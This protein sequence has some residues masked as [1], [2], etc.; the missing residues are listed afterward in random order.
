M[1][2]VDMW[3]YQGLYHGPEFIQIAPF[4]VLYTQFFFRKQGGGSNG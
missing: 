1:I 4:A 3:D 2:A